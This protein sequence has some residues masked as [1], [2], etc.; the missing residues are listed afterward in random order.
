MSN[1]TI[2]HLLGSPVGAGGSREKEQESR[3]GETEKR[4]KGERRRKRPEGAVEGTNL[5]AGTQRP[6][7]PAGPGAL[8]SEEGDT[9]VDVSPC[10]PFQGEI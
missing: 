3:K 2:R 4:E 8:G 7:A 5:G 6:P 10:D 9:S 1:L